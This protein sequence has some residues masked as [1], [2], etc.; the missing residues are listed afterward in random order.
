MKTRF[1][2]TIL[3]ISLFVS[4]TEA[5][6]YIVLG[7]YAQGGSYSVKCNIRN[8]KE[9]PRVMQAAVDSILKRIDFSLSGYNKASLLSRF[10]AG[11]R[12]TPDEL[13]LSIYELSYAFFEKSEGAFDVSCGPLFDIWG[14]GF[15]QG[16]LP[17]AARV[18]EA[19][20]RSGMSRLKKDIRSAIRPDGTL[21]GADLLANPGDTLLPVLN[22]NAIAQGFSC[23][24]VASYLH[25]LGV[26][27][28]LVD[29]GEI[30][31][32]GLN[33]SGK[34]WSVGIDTPADGN[35]T[36]GADLQGVWHSG[37][38]AGQG[39][40]TSGNY[41]KFYVSGGRKYSHTID[42]RTGAP[43]THNLLS[44]TIVAPDAA[45]ADAVATWCMVEGADKALDIVSRLGLECCLICDEGGRMERRL[46]SGFVLSTLN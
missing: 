19:M 32:E 33:A 4:C 36:P 40:V 34:P 17:D 7:G 9:T 45:T 35:N 13:F 6:R 23:D 42:P 11:E 37:G 29:I 38:G 43:V 8:V 3:C 46:S 18:E 12:I 28:M 24:C 26:R 16:S 22:F 14:F 10:N 25:G 20:K 15:K 21:S 39:V 30:Y 2:T 5:D 27:D 1:L 44:A 41:R 31:C